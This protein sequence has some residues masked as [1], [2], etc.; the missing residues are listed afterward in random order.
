MGL[1]TEFMQKK[2][3][4]AIYG[5]ESFNPETLYMDSHRARWIPGDYT[6]DSDQM[7]L[8]LDSI[9]DKNGPDYKNFSNRLFRWIFKGY[10]I[11]GML[12]KRYYK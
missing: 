11:L 5:I 6:D 8:I 12:F 7:L 9:L 1:A 2:E 10:E 4:L 3:A